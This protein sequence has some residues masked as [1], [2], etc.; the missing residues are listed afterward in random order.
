MKHLVKKYMRYAKFKNDL[1]AAISEIPVD[2][3]E[4]AR[5]QE[6]KMAGMYGMVLTDTNEL[7]QTFKYEKDGKI[8]MLPEPDPVV[9][10]FDTARYNFHEV[11]KMRVELFKQ[12]SHFGKD[13]V[14]SM[15]NFYHYYANAS[16]FAIYLFFALE[17]FIN[18]MIPKDFEYRRKIQDKKT[19]LFDKFQV[20][21]SIEF[22]EKMKD[23]IPE[24]TGK[25]FVNDF[26]HKYEQIKKLK[27]FRDEVVHTKSFEADKVP[28]FYEQL[29]VMSLDFDFEKTL[30]YVR[31]YINY[32]Q[33]DLIE[34]CNCGRD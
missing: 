32:Y 5:I 33:S 14:A 16:S 27:I 23:I 10:Y 30:Y 26:T 2:E 1:N 17:A 13:L 19:E 29:Y 20:Q 6:Q 8:F 18:K 3:T 4:I 24:I 22:P 11:T 31:D 7:Y 28:N 34:E 15:G 25:N 21:R 12:S 9:I